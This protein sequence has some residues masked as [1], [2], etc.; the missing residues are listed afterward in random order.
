MQPQRC[1]A[2][3][4]GRRPVF[5]DGQRLLDASGGRGDDRRQ[6]GGHAGRG[7]RLADGPDGGRVVRGVVASRA[8]D[9]EVDQA[10]GQQQSVE[11]DASCRT[12]GGVL[13]QGDDA[14]SCQAHAGRRTDA[15]ARFDHPYP[16]QDDGLGHNP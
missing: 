3:V 5:E 15:D 9:L 4:A 13:A 12:R 1:R 2:T 8:V 7:D 6:E 14:P 16:A 10:G 11:L